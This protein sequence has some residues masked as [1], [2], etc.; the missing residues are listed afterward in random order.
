MKNPVK[1]S[2]SKKIAYINLLSAK[3]EK[4]RREF[5]EKSSSSF[6]FFC[7]A[8]APDFYFDG[9][10]HLKKLC[11]VLQDYYDDK[12][13]VNGKPV[14]RLIIEMPPRHGKTRTL[15]LFCSWMLGKNRQ[16]KI[17]TSAY[18]DALA[19]DFSK[20]T[21]NIIEEERNDE[22]DTV[23]SDIFPKTELKHG[24]KSI[25]QWALKGMFFTFKSSGKCGTITG[26]GGTWLII[27]DPVKSEKEAFNSTALENDWNW[28]KGTWISRKEAN[29]KEIIN[30]TPWA[31]KDIGGMIQKNLKA[32]LFVFK[33]PAYN[34][35]TKK[36]LC[37]SLL[38]RET[39]KDL[40]YTM[41]GISKIIFRA[42]YDLVRVDAQ[43]SLYGQ[44]F[45]LYYDL[46]RDTEGNHVYDEHMLFVDTADTGEDYLC[47]IEAKIYNGL[48]YVVDIYY[49]QED[50]KITVPEMARRLIE[51]KVCAARYEGNSAGHAIANHVEDTLGREYNWF[52]T[53][54]ECFTQ[55]KNK[56]TRIISNAKNVKDKI[57]MP[58]DWEVKWNEF[59][60]AVTE[61]NV[62]GKNDHDDG[63]DTLTQIIEY[64]ADG[65]A[66]SS[67]IFKRR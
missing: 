34:K 39:Y 57:I 44:D 52:G 4:Q 32:G 10:D 24:D 40:K 56:K 28:Y 30:H 19:H 22:S 9:R 55:S 6:W 59:Y 27:D 13:K 45:K 48:A 16:E 67:T 53:A 60:T 65:S 20:Y 33:L 64:I 61:Y 35:K 49:T 43:G 38:S 2:R 31:K 7:K 1:L 23:Y 41:T 5:I 25:G 63:P 62:R 54:F 18:N 66:D 3:I 11:N 14:K 51:N 47:A 17:I 26:K 36:M 58:V 37:E 29:A 42:N 50:V 46:P 15:V 8:M 21:R 12:L